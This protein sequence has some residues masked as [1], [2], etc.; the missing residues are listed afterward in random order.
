M[1]HKVSGLK[2]SRSEITNQKDKI[3]WNISQKASGLR[4]SRSEITSQNDK[5]CLEYVSRGKRNKDE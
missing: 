5:N 3:A 1:S 4:M 2:M